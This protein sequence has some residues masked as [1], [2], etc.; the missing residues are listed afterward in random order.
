LKFVA[1]ESVDFQIVSRLRTD[2]HEVLYIAETHSGASDDS[3]LAQANLQSAVLLTA[4]KDFGDLVFRQRLISSGI[5][6]L[7]I[8]GLSQDG[9]AA[10]VAE[11]IS[12]HGS[13][14]PGRFTV[15][16]S[17]TLRIR[18]LDS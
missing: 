18:H 14:M 15:L 17:T 6:L 7:R 11:A 16:T 9:K 8:A 4:D 1:D 10:I 12:K 3:V 2:G 5:L 13:A